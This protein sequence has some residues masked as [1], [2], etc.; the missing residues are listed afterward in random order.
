[1]NFNDNKSVTKSAVREVKCAPL[2]V[3]HGADGPSGHESSF[4]ELRE[5]KG[6]GKHLEAIAKEEAA[7]THR[8]EK[9]G[10]LKA[11]GGDGGRVS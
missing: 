5:V 11:E 7:S 6:D 8:G 4:L 1:M 10:L 3:T 2:A 9:T